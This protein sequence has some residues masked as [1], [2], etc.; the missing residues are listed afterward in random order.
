MLL[1]LSVNG[2]DAKSPTFV[3]TFHSMFCGSALA[4]STATDVVS[5][6]TSS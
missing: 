5:A 3:G 4:K 1:T 2:A 6:A